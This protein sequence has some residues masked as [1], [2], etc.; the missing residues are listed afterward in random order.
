MSIP[1]LEQ[2]GL[3]RYEAIADNGVAWYKTTAKNLKQAKT[4]ASKMLDKYIE[5]GKCPLHFKYKVIEVKQN[6]TNG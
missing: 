5:L 4:K 6:E 1:T 2:L 3:K